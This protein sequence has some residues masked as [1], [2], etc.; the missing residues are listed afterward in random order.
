MTKQHV[1]RIKKDYFHQ[2]KNGSKTIE[3]RVGYPSVRRVHVGDSVS[4]QNY[5]ENTFL[6]K[7]ITIYDGFRQM[8]QAEGTQNV[9]PGSSLDNALR[10]FKSTYSTD[11]EALGVYAFEL[12]HV[13]KEHI[14][15]NGS[16]EDYPDQYG[17]ILSKYVPDIFSGE[18]EI[19]SCYIDCK[20]VAIAILKCSEETKNSTIYVKSTYQNQ[21]NATELLKKSFF[22]LDTATPSIVL[23]DH[24]FDQLEAAIKEHLAKT[25]IF[26]LD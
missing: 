22:W 15:T 2:L 20:I 24:E 19:I 12:K 25:Q 3:V 21:G 5:G 6:V 4:F 9:L 26:Y 13:A 10:F 11:K 16:F 18:Q 1:W 8:L 23:A 17:R 7:R 14:D